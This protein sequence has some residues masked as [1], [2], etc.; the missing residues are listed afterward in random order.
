MR[1]IGLKLALLAFATGVVWAQQ[2]LP[3]SIGDGPLNVKSD[4]AKPDKDGA[5]SPGP[6]VELPGA[7][8]PDSGTW[9]NTLHPT[10]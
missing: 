6:A 8:G 5:Y 9:E 3:P 4:Q 1:K 7:P 2:E 10:C